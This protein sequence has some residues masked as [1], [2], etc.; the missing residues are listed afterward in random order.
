MD[1]YPIWLLVI[2][3]NGISKLDGC[4]HHLHALLE[5]GGLCRLFDVIRI[6]LIEKNIMISTMAIQAW[7]LFRS[8]L[9]SSIV[10]LTLQ[11]KL[12][13]IGR[14]IGCSS[15]LLSLV[16]RHVESGTAAQ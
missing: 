14:E 8:S 4:R 15:D 5:R 7:D 13:Q 6:F 9:V 16:T 2:F 12:S 1:P 10:F 11:D 3:L